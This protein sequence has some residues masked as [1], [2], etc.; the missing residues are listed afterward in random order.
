MPLQNAPYPVGPRDVR[1]IPAQRAV[2]IDTSCTMPY[3]RPVFMPA[4]HMITR[5]MSRVY[6]CHKNRAKVCASLQAA[7]DPLWY[8]MN[9][10]SL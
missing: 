3:L 1:D 8:M 9:L 10:T 6:N 7:V 2:T 5:Y 4:T